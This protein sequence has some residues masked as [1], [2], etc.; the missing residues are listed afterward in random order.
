[1]ITVKVPA[2]SANCS[3]GFDT[4]GLALNWYSSITFE[5]AMSCSSA[6]VPGNTPLPTIWFGHP[7]CSPAIS[8]AS[9][10]QTYTSTFSPI[11]RLPEA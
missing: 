2:T 3:V 6:A 7:L 4:L 10:F 8:A 1:M 11:F 9:R 5:K